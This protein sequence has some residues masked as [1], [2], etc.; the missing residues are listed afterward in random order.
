MS[1]DVARRERNKSRMS[2]ELEPEETYALA[3]G[4]GEALVEVEVATLPELGPVRP[5]GR[6]RGQRAL[7]GGGLATSR[8]PSRFE[9]ALRGVRQGAPEPPL[10]PAHPKRR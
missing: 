10:G 8:F 9:R 7:A 6:G 4:C 5:A 1:L 3:T 2:W